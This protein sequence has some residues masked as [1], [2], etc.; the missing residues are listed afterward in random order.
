MEKLYELWERKK[1]VFIFGGLLL[2]SLL[3]GATTSFFFSKP[4]NDSIFTSMS[5][6]KEEKASFPVASSEKKEQ[7][8]DAVYVDVKGAVKNPG[9]Y[10]LNKGSRL[11]D[12][13][14]KAGGLLSDAN[15]KQINQARLL[16]DQQM[17]YIPKNGEDNVVEE[18]SFTHDSNEKTIERDQQEKK[19]KININQAD[20]TTLQQLP[21]I[22]V[23][24]AEAIIQYRNEK[25]S[26]KKIEHITEIA[27][28]GEATFTKLKEL[29]TI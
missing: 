11:M 29:I 25:G 14:E 6:Q 4:Q 16:N 12:A 18:L 15:G 22:G 23:K 28:I 10:R 26:F 3:L 20:Q 2:G 5:E 1:I 13:I 21:G 8:T 24:K 7:T 17:I 9:V 19:D 27:G